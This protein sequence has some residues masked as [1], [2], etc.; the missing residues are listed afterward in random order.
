MKLLFSHIA[1]CVLRY[2]HF[3]CHEE[4]RQNITGLQGPKC[5]HQSSEL[6]IKH[7]ITDFKMKIT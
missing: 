4:L 6:C 5:T 3:M 7:H 2:V 1:V